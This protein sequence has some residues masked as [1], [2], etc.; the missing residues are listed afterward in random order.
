MRYGKLYSQGIAII[1]RYVTEGIMIIKPI[2]TTDAPKAIGPY[3]QANRVGNLIFTSG[4]LGIDMA[5]G[6]LAVGVEEQTRCALINLGSI[7]KTASSGYGN[8]LKTTVFL[9]NMD[10][11]KAV[12]AVYAEFFSNGYPARS[13]VEVARL[14]MGGLVEIECVAVAEDA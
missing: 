9:D 6:K 13:C 11:F 10:D 4:Q 14:P 8:I 1:K 2:S 7:L 3:A 5:T 12:N